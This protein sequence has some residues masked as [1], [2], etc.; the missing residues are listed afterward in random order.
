MTPIPPS[1]Q[2]QS[3]GTDAIEMRS[4]EIQTEPIYIVQFNDLNDHEQYF[5]ALNNQEKLLP[6]QQEHLYA[7]GSQMNHHQPTISYSLD[8][9]KKQCN[10]L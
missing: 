3:I 6:H 1:L 7:M 4:I 10:I 8:S 9:T 5:E 2:S